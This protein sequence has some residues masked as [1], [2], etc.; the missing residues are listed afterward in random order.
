MT[1]AKP[2]TR[3]VCPHPACGKFTTLRKDGTIRK[4]HYHDVSTWGVYGRP[5]LV[6]CPMSGREPPEDVEKA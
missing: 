1:S 4:H 2:G 5:R 6:L 3:I